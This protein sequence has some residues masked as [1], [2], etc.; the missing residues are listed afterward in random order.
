MFDN[1]TNPYCLNDNRIYNHLQMHDQKKEVQKVEQRILT[2]PVS[3]T[4]LHPVK[5]WL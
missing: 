5:V 1:P 4:T 3:T 2:M